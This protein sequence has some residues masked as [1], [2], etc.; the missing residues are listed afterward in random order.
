MNLK[1]YTPSV[2]I[3]YFRADA[4]TLELSE[5]FTHIVVGASLKFIPNPEIVL[6]K[7]IG[8]LEDEGVILASPFYIKESI[9]ND[10]IVKAKNVFGITPTTETYKEVMRLYSELEIL[11]E[12]RCDIFQETDE[13]INNYCHH[14]IHRACDML[15]ISD[16]SVYLS[17]ID[18]LREIRNMSN[19]LR[20]YQSYSVLIL[21]H[22]NCVHPHRYIELF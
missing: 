13:E 18:R 3:S 11:Y 2:D 9:P 5:K 20:P 21:R 15:N 16:D 7:C 4:L 10:L 8:W 19:S 6:K 1:R 22:R 17:M 14:T 12:D